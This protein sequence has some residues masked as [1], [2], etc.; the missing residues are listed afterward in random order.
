MSDSYCPVCGNTGIDPTTGQVCNCKW[1]SDTF[2]STVSCLSI[3]VQYQGLVF[4]KILTPNDLGEE[5]RDYLEN[6]YGDITMLRMQYHNILLCSPHQHSKTIL[7]YS[8]IERL[9][10]ESLPVFP[11][12]DIME[13]RNIINAIDLGKKPAYSYAEDPENI[14]E[15]SYLF[16]KIPLWPTWECFDTINTLIGRRIRRGHST[17][18][19]YSGT[20][21]QLSYADKYEAITSLRGNGSYSTLEIKSFA[22]TVKEE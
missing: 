9:F 11:V 17:I 13:L 7:A 2:F 22:P 18:F 20:W 19:L 4:N 21:S 12:C 6:L 1:N 14:I 16:A 8:C 15:A 5:Y 10:R 3:P